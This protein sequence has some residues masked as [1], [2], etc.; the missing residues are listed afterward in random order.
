MEG[1]R[2]SRYCL[3]LGDNNLVTAF[4]TVG[5]NTWTAPTGVTAIEVLVVGGQAQGK[6][7][8]SLKHIG[9]AMANAD[10]HVGVDSGY[11]HL[12][13]LYFKPE[14]IYIYTNKK[15]RYICFGNIM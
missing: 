5:A 15:G 3:L 13:Q 8:R 6:L 11:M 4:T 12:A 9:Y 2:V 10:F 7:R 14:N 1:V